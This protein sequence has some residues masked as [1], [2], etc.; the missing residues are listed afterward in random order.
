MA[1][2]ELRILGHLKK[3]SLEFRGVFEWDRF[4]GSL[5]GNP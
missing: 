3:D 2:P 4:H 5:C 1:Y